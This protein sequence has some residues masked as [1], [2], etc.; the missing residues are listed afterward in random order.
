MTKPFYST[1]LCFI[2]FICWPKVSL[3]GK[4]FTSIKASQG[5]LY[6]C[7]RELMTLYFFLLT[8]TIVNYE[9]VLPSITKVEND[10][11]VSGQLSLYNYFNEPL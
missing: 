8:E 2:L 6:L 4:P 11:E 7:K 9:E 5:K 3:C 1:L 10:N